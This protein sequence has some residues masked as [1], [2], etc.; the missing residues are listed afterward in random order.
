MSVPP[1]F[2]PV[3]GPATPTSSP[4]T[5]PSLRH[6]LAG[7]TR[8]LLL[9]GIT[10]PRA[11]ATNE[12]ARE[13]ARLTLARLDPLDVD[14]LVLYDIDDE[15]DRNPDERPFPYLPTMD[16]AVFHAAHLA[17]WRRPAIVYRCVGKYPEPELRDWLRAV[18]TD[19]VGGVFVGASS[20]S[21]QVHTTLPR[22]HALRRETRPDL[23]VGG[24]AIPERH[25]RG[26]DE[27]LRM[28]T[29]QERGCGFFVSQVIYDVDASKS[30]VSDYHYA[31]RDRGVTPRPVVFTL[32][33]CG[34]LRTLAFL[35]WLGV[36]VPRWL[37][38]ALR[39][40][41]DPLAESYE[42]CL[43]TAR[44]LVTFCRRLGM[45][46][47]FNVESVSNR[48]LEIDASVA[49]AA[50]VRDLLGRPSA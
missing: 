4:G 17:G 5:G 24:V 29:K 25:T 22:A 41:D 37:E 19:R 31:C 30:M 27:H 36:R 42:Q 50:R 21:K 45:P 12:Q 49:L 28:L 11:S 13:I 47:G 15:S 6:V 9:F 39:H 18:D 46:F 23:A 26:L 44:E 35:Q 33:V 8:G 20:G 16:P 48:K 38:N 1:P 3:D 2:S 14:A 40:A 34:S 10:P 43:A 32:S 7:A